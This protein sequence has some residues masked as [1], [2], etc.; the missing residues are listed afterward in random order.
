MII[1]IFN[2]K[3]GV[4]KTTTAINLGAALSQL[5]KRVLIVD[6]DPQA[7]ATVGFGLNDEELP[8][9]IYSLLTSKKVKKERILEVIKKTSYENLDLLPADI[10]LSD[11]E[12]TLSQVMSRETI[13]SRILEQID[14]E[15]DYIF[16][17]CPPSLGLLSINSLVAS[18]GLIIP[19]TASYF[20]IKGIK[21][22]LNTVQLVQENLKPELDILGVLITNYDA[23]KNIAKEVRASLTKAFG[24]KVFSAIIRTNSQI[25]YAQ[26]AQ[27][28]IIFFNK[29]SHGFDDYMELAQEVLNYERK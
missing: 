25:E 27:Q 6:T 24:D 10:T 1:S 13:L 14:N 16:I 18:D 26:D 5:G 22:L 2:Q 23:R 12:I 8:E 20:S 9:T 19:V 15:Y 3:G 28:P 29:K 7:N 4:A 11:A 21:H 17:D